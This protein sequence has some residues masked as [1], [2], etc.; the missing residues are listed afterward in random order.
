M[1]KK[2]KEK[3]N[4]N[5]KKNKRDQ[6]KVNLINFTSSVFHALRRSIIRILQKSVPF[7]SE[8]GV[9]CMWEVL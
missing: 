3:N 8:K 9:I 7:F 1:M 5:F 6:P 4:K 2:S